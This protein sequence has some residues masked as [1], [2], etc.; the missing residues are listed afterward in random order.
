MAATRQQ[1]AGDGLM[2]MGLFFIALEAARVF[3]RRPAQTESQ[4]VEQAIPLGTVAALLVASGGIIR[5]R[6][7]PAK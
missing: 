3:T 2:M 6:A 4:A 5:G 1:V 7:G